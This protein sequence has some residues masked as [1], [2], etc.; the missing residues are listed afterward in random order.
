MIRAGWRTPDVETSND[1]TSPVE[2]RSTVSDGSGEASPRERGKPGMAVTSA[3]PMTAV[4]S[5]CGPRRLVLSVNFIVMCVFAPLLLRLS[6]KVVG[7]N[8]PVLTGEPFPLYQ[9]SSGV[10]S[11]LPDPGVR[12]PYC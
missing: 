9:K 5:M 8:I 12:N 6:G 11:S 2:N 7:E 10:P 4:A 3:S 1:G